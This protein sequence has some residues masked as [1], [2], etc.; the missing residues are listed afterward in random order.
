MVNHA[1]KPLK[2]ETTCQSVT[3]CGIVTVGLTR[4]T[5]HTVNYTILDCSRF[6][7]VSPNETTRGHTCKLFVCHSHSLGIV[8]S[9]QVSNK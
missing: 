8:L 6:F 4:S 3:H 5:L 2:R 9:F 7:T 1:C